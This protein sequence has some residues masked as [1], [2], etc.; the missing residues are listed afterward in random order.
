MKRFDTINVIPFIDIILVLL[1]IVL[2]TAS[3]IAKGQIS[4]ELPAS[5][6]AE[7]KPDA[8]A[9]EITIDHKQQIFFN[10]AVV[11]ID[12][13]SLQLSELKKDNPVILRV[14][15]GVPFNAFVSVVDILKAENMNRLTIQTRRAP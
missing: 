6:A 15:A 9:V 1:A 14:D 11:G 12:E 3:F 5:N 8:K 10:A 4:I 2:T 7:S 13:L